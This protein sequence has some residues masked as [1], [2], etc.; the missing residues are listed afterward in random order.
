M[1]PGSHFANF[2]EPNGW[3][4]RVAFR[5]GRM[6]LSR[7]RCFCS[8]LDELEL[9]KVWTLIGWRRQARRLTICGGRF[10]AS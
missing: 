9:R 1:P 4:H 7:S 10:L 5:G 3:P 8:M 2:G 6:W